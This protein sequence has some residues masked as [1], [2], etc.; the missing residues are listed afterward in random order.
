[1][2]VTDYDSL[3]LSLI[4]WSH[5]EDVDTK[6][7]EFID[8]A[9][10]E[11]YANP[12][13]PLQIRSEETRVAFTTNTTDRFVAL[14]TG[15]QSFRKVR[16]QVTNGQ[17]VPLQ[18]R[19]PEQLDIDNIAGMPRFFTVT[20]QIEFNRISDIVYTGEFQYIQE[21][22]K[23]SDDNTTNIVLTNHPTIY[24]YGCLWALKLWAEEVPEAEAYYQRF[25]N[26]IKGANKKDKLGRYGPAPI[27]RVDAVTP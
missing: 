25:I 9:E 14:P 21:F 5:R 22:T 7:D 24:M 19:T 13:A 12:L 3:K 4:D 11:M 2:A 8:L 18:F 27:M 6:I 17:S 16:I 26:A 23:L 10:S 20:D 15:Y 1:M